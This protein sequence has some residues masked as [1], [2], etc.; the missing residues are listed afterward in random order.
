M[1]PPSPTPTS[2]WFRVE[3]GF[4]VACMVTL[5]LLS[6]SQI[7]L[8]NAFSITLLWADPLIRHLVLWI[9]FIGAL[10]ATRRDR[11]VKMDAMQ[12]L[13][14]PKI[15]SL[16]TIIS[17]L[18]SFVVCALLS[19]HAGRFVA[20]EYAYST[21]AFSDIA[22]WK[23]QLVFPLVFTAMALR[24]ARYTLSSVVAVFGTTTQPDQP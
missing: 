7:F 24:Y 9:G 17:H 12:R 6:F 3:D 23:L 13:F 2:F 1:K 21:K 8:R 22:A 19:W 20:D 15:R 11:H 18:F 14:S 16:S 10:G 4:L 5:L